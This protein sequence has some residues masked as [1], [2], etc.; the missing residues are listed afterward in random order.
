LDPFGNLIGGIGGDL[1]SNKITDYV[2]G[3][4]PWPRVAAYGNKPF[5]IEAPGP[6]FRVATTVLPSSLGSVIVAQSLADFDRT[7]RQI[8]TV[9]LIIGS[10]VLLSIAFA[11]AKSLSRYASLGKD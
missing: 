3:L 4:L 1:N 8:G 11:S 10:L 9:F 7:T 2:K 6:D 5:T